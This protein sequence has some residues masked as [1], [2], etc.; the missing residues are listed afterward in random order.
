MLSTAAFSAKRISGC[1]A[2]YFEEPRRKGVTLANSRRAA[3]QCD[4]DGLGN[5]LCQMGVVN[6]TQASGIDP[7]GVNFDKFGKR[8]G[9]SM[10]SVFQK[11]VEIIHSGLSLHAFSRTSMGRGDRKICST[12]L[13][14]FGEF[15]YY[16]IDYGIRFDDAV[17]AVEEVIAVEPDFFGVF[18]GGGLEGVGHYSGD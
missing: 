1:E 4:E 12:G 17:Y 11:Q 14:C 16:V 6:Q 2:N 8:L 13:F 18:W 9:R 7:I 5:V 10:L 15:F 3:R